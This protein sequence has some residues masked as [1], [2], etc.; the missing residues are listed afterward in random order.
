MVLSIKTK[1]CIA[2]WS[3]PPPYKA[4]LLG[5]GLSASQIQAKLKRELRVVTS[6][7]TQLSKFQNSEI[8]VLEVFFN[9]VRSGSSPEKNTGDSLF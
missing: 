8:Q 5:P 3:L 2:I 1:T 9:L 6:L 4:Y 7:P